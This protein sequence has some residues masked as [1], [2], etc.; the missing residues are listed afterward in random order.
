[1][2]QSKPPSS[3]SVEY[4]SNRRTSPKDQSSEPDFEFNQDTEPYAQIEEPIIEPDVEDEDDYEKAMRAADA[5]Y[6]NREI[7]PP[8]QRRPV[9]EQ[10]APSAAPKV[11]AP[12][13]PPSPRPAPKISAPQPSSPPKFFGPPRR[14]QPAF[15]Q[16]PKDA[17]HAAAEKVFA[18]PAEP[19]SVEPAAATPRVLQDLTEKPPVVFE[20]KRRG[21]PPKV[22]EAKRRGRP[23]KVVVVGEQPEKVAKPQ[24]PKEQEFQWAAETVAEPT[25]KP[26]ATKP[27]VPIAEIIQHM[28]PVSARIRFRDYS[29]QAAISAARRARWAKKPNVS[30][31]SRFR[32]D[33]YF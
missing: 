22:V 23:P 9:D 18:K 20:A 26:P 31:T 25:K 33:R 28:V 15:N 1:M 5:A 29:D 12:V 27:A 6:A 2:R 8:L 32:H 17:A 21:R 16:N 7:I 13:S 30:A 10:V 14:H 3:F 4:R 24:E 11:P 19:V